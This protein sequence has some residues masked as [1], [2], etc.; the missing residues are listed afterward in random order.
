MAL[1]SKTIRVPIDTLRETAEKMQDY[2][3]EGSELFARL[4]NAVEAVNSNAE[5]KGDSMNAL[6]AVTEKNQK[7][8]NETMQ[9]LSDLA[10]FMKSFADKIEAKDLEIKDSIRAE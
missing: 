8:L 7:S 3:D 4:K 10:T 9:E 2:A 6:I 1:F 5:W